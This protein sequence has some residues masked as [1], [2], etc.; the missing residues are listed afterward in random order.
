MSQLILPSRSPDYFWTERN[1]SLSA[2][3]FIVIVLDDWFSC[4]STFVKWLGSVSFSFKLTSWV[5]QGYVLS[6]YLFA[7]Y[8]D[9]L[10][11]DIVR[12][13]GGCTFHFVSVCIVVYAD[14]II[15]LAP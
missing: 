10:I 8:I 5:R 1:E 9:D 2:N 7:V 14:D 6:S 12:Q 11:I 4:C 15:L 13:S 3:N